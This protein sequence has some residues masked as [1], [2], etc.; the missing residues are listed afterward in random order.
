MTLEE[1]VEIYYQDKPEGFGT[2]TKD[3]IWGYRSAITDAARVA[4]EWGKAYPEE[5]NNKL[6]NQIRALAALGLN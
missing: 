5:V 4:E 1:L 6:A 3:F 2:P